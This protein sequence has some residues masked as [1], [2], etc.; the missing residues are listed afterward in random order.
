MTLEERPRVQIVLQR[1]I[2]HHHV[3]HACFRADAAGQ[4]GEDDLVDVEFADQRDGGGGGRHLAHAGEHEH[5]RMPM[6][7]A[8]VVVAHADG[9][10]LRARIFVLHGGDERVDFIVDGGEDTEGHDN[11]EDRGMRGA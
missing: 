4:T 6:Q 11:A 1:A 2:G 8:H 7:F 3:A 9:V 10:H 5:A